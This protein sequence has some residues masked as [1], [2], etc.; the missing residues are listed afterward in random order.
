MNAL[1]ETISVFWFLFILILYD[2]IVIICKPGFWSYDMSLFSILVLNIF[3]LC[4]CFYCIIIYIMCVLKK[5]KKNKHFNCKD[6]PPP[7]PMEDHYSILKGPSC[8]LMQP[9]KSSSQSCQN[10]YIITRD[11]FM[12]CLYTTK[13]NNVLTESKQ[14][15]NKLGKCTG[16]NT[17]CIKSLNGVKHIDSYKMIQQIIPNVKENNNVKT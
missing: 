11:K 4:C 3:V 9:Y 15:K 17:F 12:S 16:I 2:C 8:I 6:R 1:W 13:R 5:N 10:L 14:I 7:P